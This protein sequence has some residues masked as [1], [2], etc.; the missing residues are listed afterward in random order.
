MKIPGAGRADGAGDV[1]GGELARPAGGLG[2]TA[3]AGFSTV[4]VDT[5]VRNAARAAAGCGCPRAAC[6]QSSRPARSGRAG[7]GD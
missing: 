1:A 7:A 3:R 6:A 2:R 5:G 4:P